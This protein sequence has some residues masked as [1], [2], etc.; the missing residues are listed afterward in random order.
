VHSWS[1]MSTEWEL[2][3]R[4]VTEVHWHPGRFLQ[5]SW[6][7]T[8]SKSTPYGFYAKTRTGV[9]GICSLLLIA[10]IISSFTDKKKKLQSRMAKQLLEHGRAG[11]EP[12]SGFPQILGVRP[13]CKRQRWVSGS[14]PRM[15]KDIKLV[16]HLTSSLLQ[17]DPS[18]SG[19]R[20][21]KG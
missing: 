12:S 17:R 16:G 20:G 19:R 10:V 21:E 3:N 5:T 4:N 14:C 2:S 9:T 6:K 11:F 7:V 15:V 13:G 1:L 18:L 8:V